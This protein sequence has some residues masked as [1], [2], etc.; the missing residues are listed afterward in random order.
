MGERKERD[1]EVPTAAIVVIG[2]EILSG[3][4]S[5]ENASYRMVATYWETLDRR[6]QGGWYGNNIDQNMVQEALE[7][8]ASIRLWAVP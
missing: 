4:F 1:G 5:E 7:L 8:L 3:K 6:R 2:D